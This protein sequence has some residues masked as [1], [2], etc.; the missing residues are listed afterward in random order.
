MHPALDIRTLSKLPAEHK[1]IALT[2]SRAE[3]TLEDLRNLQKLVRSANEKHRIRYLPAFYHFL[4]PSKIP[5]PL[6]WESP[7]SERLPPLIARIVYALRGTLRIL[8]DIGSSRDLCLACWDRL[9]PW[10]HFLHQYHDHLAST[11]ESPDNDEPPYLTVYAWFVVFAARL[12]EEHTTLLSGT[13]GFRSVLARAWRLAP[14]FQETKAYEPFLTSLAR[15]L[16]SLTF[17]DTAHIAELISGAG[18]AP[19][20]LAPLIVHYL[21]HIAAR[22]STA[23]TQAPGYHFSCVLRLIMVFTAR[24]AAPDDIPYKNFIDVLAAHGLVLAFIG[25]M[26]SLLDDT[27][28]RGVAM[29][30]GALMVVENLLAGPQGCQLLPRAIRAGFLSTLAQMSIQFGSGL[31]EEIR[32]FVR[33]FLPPNM[34]YYHVAVAISEVIDELFELVQSPELQS[35]AISEDFTLCIAAGAK[36]AQLLDEI[37]SDETVL[38]ACDNLACGEIHERSRLRRCSK[39]RSS[40]YCTREC[41]IADWRNG[42]HSKIC[43]SFTALTLSSCPSLCVD[44]QLSN[45]TQI[46]ESQSCQLGFRERQFL[47]TLVQEAYD[48]DINFICVEQLMLMAEDHQP[49]ILFD[50]TCT[51]Q[52]V[53]V[54]SVEDSF[55]LKILHESGAFAQWEYLAERARASGGRMRLHVIRVVEGLRKRLWVIPLRSSSN[56]IEEDLQWCLDIVRENPDCGAI[57]V[58]EGVEETLANRGDLVEIH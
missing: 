33:T 21:A 40:Y 3:G 48:E 45:Q 42:G 5:G 9:W 58:D 28:H 11:I 53:S 16:G 35:R 14:T 52:Q 7:Q 39:C 22:H 18:G 32:F 34:V 25:A 17:S 27:A 41:Q 15:F 36:R 46:D 50:F 23:L 26:R 43:G 10:T 2:A 57:G 49:F 4:D 47:R 37:D 54:E 20:D 38:R 12:H 24:K 55:I 1:A 56:F 51:P 44:S 31:D 6:D 30:R 13:P 19:H 29:G 8:T